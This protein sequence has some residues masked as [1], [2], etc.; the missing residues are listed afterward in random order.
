MQLIPLSRERSSTSCGAWNEHILCS[1]IPGKRHQPH[2]PAQAKPVASQK[3][4]TVQAHDPNAQ[5][6]GERSLPFM[7]FEQEIAPKARDP[8]TVGGNHRVT[9]FSGL[10]VSGTLEKRT[11][12][13][14]RPRK[15]GHTM[16]PMRRTAPEVAGRPEGQ[17]IVASRVSRLKCA[18]CART[19]SF[20]PISVTASARRT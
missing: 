18:P 19:C 14:E 5:P 13:P 4:M 12:S 17:S 16:I 7:S 20:S 1:Y 3:H 11:G 15:R 9:P 10:R 2:H 6:N 8:T